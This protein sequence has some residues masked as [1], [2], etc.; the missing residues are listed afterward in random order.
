[1]ENKSDDEIIK[2]WTI[3]QKEEEQN[4]NSNSR[5]RPRRMIEASTT[6]S[7]RTSTSISENAFPVD[8]PAHHSSPPPQQARQPLLLEVVNGPKPDTQT[9]DLI[10]LSDSYKATALRR[11]DGV[12]LPAFE[13]QQQNPR[14]IVRLP[15]TC[16]YQALVPETATPPSRKTPSGK[17]PSRQTLVT[18]ALDLEGLLARYRQ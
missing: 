5:K 14:I 12:I 10:D 15:P 17:T 16:S 3:E 9:P 4:Q 2:R 11:R 8:A 7:I 13:Q 1:M 6:H 18:G